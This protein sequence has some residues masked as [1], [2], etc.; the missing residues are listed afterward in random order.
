M[1]HKSRF[2]R[3]GTDQFNPENHDTLVVP[4]TWNSPGV[5]VMP[6][7]PEDGQSLW[8]C[9]CFEKISPTTALTINGNGKQ[10]C[11]PSAGTPEPQTVYPG[12]FTAPFGTVAVR[13]IQFRFCSVIETWCCQTPVSFS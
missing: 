11:N 1:S 5:L 2:L 10:V 12:T 9:D 8:V 7:H 3:A 13:A 4:D 6:K